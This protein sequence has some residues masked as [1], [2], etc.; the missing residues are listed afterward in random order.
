M[1]I[2]FEG[3]IIVVDIDRMEETV[4]ERGWSEY[5]PNPATGK[6]SQLIEKFASK[7]GAVI[8]YGLDW[9]RG[10]EEAVIEIPLTDPHDVKDDLVEI[11][12]E[13]EE[14]GVTLTIVAIRSPIT[15]R[16]ARSRREAYSGYRRRAKKILES[17]KRKGGGTVYID[18]EIVYRRGTPC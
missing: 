10:T 13:M 6:L 5:K 3:T 4:K 8:V 11:A 7:W 9:E 2:L 15:G 14:T 18:G 16:P 1:D 12:R 17:L